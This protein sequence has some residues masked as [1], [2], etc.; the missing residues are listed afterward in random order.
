[1][2]HGKNHRGEIVPRI[3]RRSGVMAPLASEIRLGQGW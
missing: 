2:I 1:M 3:L